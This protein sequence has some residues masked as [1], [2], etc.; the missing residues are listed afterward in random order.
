MYVIVGFLDAEHHIVNLQL[1]SPVV[2]FQRLSAFYKTS[3]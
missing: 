3:Y 1:Y 2:E